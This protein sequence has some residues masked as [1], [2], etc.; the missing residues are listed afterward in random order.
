M[1]PSKAQRAAAAEKRKKAVALR[2]AGL[3]WDDIAQQTG[4]ASAGAACTAVTEAMKA[5]LAAQG[6]AAT[7]L[8]ETEIAR[9]DRLQAAH[10]PK[11][12]KGDPK[13]S[14]IVLKCIAAR[15]KLQGTEAPV[16]TEHSGG[17]RYEIIGIPEADGS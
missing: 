7:E 17:L 2:L 1:P 4:Y 8:R 11:A 14:E 9:L 3:P 16:R 12:L 6:E 15:A 13:S 10:W 5:N